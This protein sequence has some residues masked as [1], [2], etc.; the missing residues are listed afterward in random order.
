MPLFQALALRAIRSELATLSGSRSELATLSGP[1]SDALPL[2]QA[3]AP[4]A[5]NI[6]YIYYTY[7]NLL[8][9]GLLLATKVVQS[10]LGCLLREGL[11]PRR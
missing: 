11:S 7:A 6:I 9:V 1:S 10:S 8:A 5:Y 2:F 4:G 3:L